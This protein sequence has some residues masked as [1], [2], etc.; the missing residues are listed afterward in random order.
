MF[1][2]Y[3]L[4]ALRQVEFV[5][6]TDI[7]VHLND[8]PSENV[9]VGIVRARTPTFFRLPIGEHLLVFRDLGSEKLL[10]SA[11]IVVPSLVQYPAKVRKSVA[12]PKEHV[13]GKAK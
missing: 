1:I 6:P 8:K 3:K 9:L 11:S 7:E 4:S 13:Y 10:G 12:L 5:S 2:V